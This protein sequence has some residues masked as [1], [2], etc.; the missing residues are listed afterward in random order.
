MK[1]IQEGLTPR[2]ICDKYH[3]IHKEIYDWFDID[4][5]YFGRTT[6]DKQTEIAQNIFREID[7]NSII[8]S[9][10]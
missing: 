4:F 6:T 9:F 10:Q 3:K 1:A 5:D 8:I 2:Q 7:Q